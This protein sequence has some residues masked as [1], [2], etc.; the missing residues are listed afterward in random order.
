MG[1]ELFLIDLYKWFAY[2]LH[3]VLGISI[4]IFAILSWYFILYFITAFKKP[5]ALKKGSRLYKYAILVPARNEDK[6]IKG[7]LDS[8]KNQTYDKNYYDVYVIVESKDDPTNKIV[9]KY[10]KHF[11]TIIRKDLNNK[12]TKGYALDEA[13]KYI[14]ENNLKYDAF[15]VFDAD[16]LVNSNYIELM[17]D[18]KNAGYKVGVGYRN[19]TNASVNWVSGCSAILFSFINNIISSGRSRFFNKC[20]LTGTGYYIDFDIID[21][22]KGW[23][24]NG[25]TEDAE[26]TSYCYSHNISMYYYRLAM[27]YDEQSSSMS[28][29]HKQHIRWIFGFFASKKKFKKNTFDYG[30][31]YG[32][33]RFFANWDY[34]LGVMPFVILIIIEVLATLI[35]LGLFISSLIT[36]SLPQYSQYFVENNVVPVCF[37]NFFLSFLYLYG[38]FIIIALLVF[39]IDNKNL[40]FKGNKI[41]I[42]SMTFLFYFGDFFVALLDGL[43]N[44]KKRTTWQRIEHIGDVTSKDA[45]KVKN[46]KKKEKR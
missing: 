30:S 23:I 10:G 3:I 29:V 41:I 37:W 16:N 40:K 2:S 46:E 35:G 28:V 45:K 36:R 18:V 44:K 17:N 25:M 15:L 33:K 4:L 34:T 19:F 22:E 27:F 1:D 24:F 32:T 21:N 11:K 9:S 42:T 26:L 13:Y 12:R 20:S 31:L 7:I 14:K 43:F 6:V 8:L 38:T 39:V 5:K